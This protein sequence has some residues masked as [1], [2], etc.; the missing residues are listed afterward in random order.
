MFDTKRTGIITADSIEKESFR[1]RII[2]LLRALRNC[3]YIK[4]IKTQKYRQTIF[5]IKKC[6]VTFKFSNGY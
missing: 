6:A 1:H 5:F 2:V 3:Y 4:T